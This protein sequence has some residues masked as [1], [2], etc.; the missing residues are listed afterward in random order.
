MRGRGRRGF[1]AWVRLIAGIVI[2]TLMTTPVLADELSE[3]RQQLAA[4]HKVMQVLESRM[5]ELETK[6]KERAE[7]G[8][9]FGY[10]A[11]TRKKG[12]AAEDVY[13]NGFFLRSKDGRYSIN[14][15]GF[16]QA[17]YT[18]TA[19][20]AGKSRNNFDVALGPTGI[21]RECL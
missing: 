1:V 7:H 2:S 12:L 9:D 8:V 4:Q 5:M 17:R 18:L 13:D 16:L 21:L 6:E 10:T 15:N 14:L 11:G 3:L 19:P 20:N